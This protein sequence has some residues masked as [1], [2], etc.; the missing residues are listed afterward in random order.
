MPQR[1]TH[2]VQI[3][4][5]NDPEARSPAELL[6]AWPTLVDVAEAASQSGVRVSV[7]QASAHLPGES[8]LCER[9]RRGA[10][11]FNATITPGSS[12]S[13]ENSSVIGIRVS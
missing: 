1:L 6:N 12:A 13:R 11:G 9:W 10:I 7:V 4:F 2:A 5:F 8:P 3:S